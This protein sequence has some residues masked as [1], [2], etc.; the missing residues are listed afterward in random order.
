MIVRIAYAF[1]SVFQT[2]SLDSMWD[3]LYGSAGIFVA[4]ALLMEYIAVL[5]FIAVGMLI[6]N[7]NKKGLRPANAS[8][9]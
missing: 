6:P 5:L 9:A 3:A 7:V 2:D 4:M 1:L 8:S